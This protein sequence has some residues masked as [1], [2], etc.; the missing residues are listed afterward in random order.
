[1]LP[2]LTELLDYL[3]DN[4]HEKNIKSV[5]ELHQRAL[6]WEDVP[7]LPVI[8]SYPYPEDVEYHPFPHKQIFDDPEKMLFNQLISAFDSSIYL[9]G[10]IGDDL[11]LTIRADFGCILIPS[12]FGAVVEQVD[13]NPPWIRHD[14]TEVDIEQIIKKSSDDFNMQHILKSASYY[15]IFRDILSDYPGLKKIINLTLPDLQGPFDNLELI[16]GSDIFL[17]M[18]LKKDDFLNAMIAVTSAQ[19]EIANYFSS[20][21]N[22]TQPGFSHQHGF[23]LKGGILIRND[24]SIMISPQMYDK[25]IATFDEEILSIFGGGIHC[26]G[27]IDHIVSHFLSLPNVQCFDFGQSELNNVEQIYKL[28]KQKSIPLMRIAVTEQELLNGKIQQK[29]PTGVSLIFRAKSFEHAKKV[30]ASYKKQN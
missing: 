3:Q 26:C 20:L 21:V 13:N 23:P 17:D 24:T 27:S 9:S 30:I 11:P 18:Q 4:L 10:E 14:E 16:R 22:E 12:M 5:E 28:A 19:V 2:E 6:A 7:R 1:M 8:A 25:L 29:Y 15:K